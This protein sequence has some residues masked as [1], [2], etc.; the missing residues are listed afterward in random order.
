MSSRSSRKGKHLTWNDRLT[1]ERMLLKGFH[2]KDIAAA[3]GCCLATVYNEIKRA[4]YLHTNCELIDEKRYCPDIAQK[5]YEEQLKHKGIKPKL[6]SCPT[7]IEYIEDMIIR[8]RYSPE[9]ILMHMRNIQLS[10][11]VEI[12]SVGTIYDGIRKGYFPNLTMQRLPYGGRKRRKEH[13]K[14]QK[15]ASRG[16]SIEKRDKVILNRET[17]GNWEM[18]CVVGKS[19]NRKTILV[20]TERKTRYTILE[21]LKTHTTGEVI[22]ALN[23]IEKRY[24]AGFYDIFQTITV[25]NGSEFS[26]YE[27]MEKARRRKGNR[28]KVYYCHPSAPHERGSNEVGNRLIRRWLPKG[29][30]FDKNLSR[31]ELKNIEFWINTYPRKLLNGDCAEDHFFKELNQIGIEHG[32]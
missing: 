16:T 28:T 25:D 26:D 19:T 7:L 18:D 15:R 1:I 13:I 6:P 27:G 32:G 10:F 17:C 9:A 21:L 3:V 20:L 30:D 24:G 29:T 4:T 2:K 8:E 5:K 14:R 31:N 23:R 12:K 22:K 11:G